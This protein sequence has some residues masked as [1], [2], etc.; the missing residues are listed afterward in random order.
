MY[1]ESGKLDLI[2]GCMFTKKT[3]ELLDKLS[4]L[5]ETGLRV[6]YINH[7]RDIRDDEVSTH[8][9]MI[10]LHKIKSIKNLDFIKLDSLKGIRKEEYDIIG[11][12]EAQFFDDS[13]IEFVK[14]H[15]DIY[16]KHLIVCGLDG[17]SNR[18]KFGYILDLIPICDTIEKKRTYCTICAKHFKQRKAIFSY[19]FEKTNS[20]IGG[21]ETYV[22]LCRN[23]Y[24]ENSKKH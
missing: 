1:R 4:I 19:K 5:S 8:N 24:N 21:K 22:A 9:K 3:S 7:M 15:V 12:D 20:D 11:I 14:V 2:I 16:K 6:L 17:N 10:D 23:C 13:L 18:E